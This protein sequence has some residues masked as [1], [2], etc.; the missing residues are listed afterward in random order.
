MK[1]RSCTDACKKPTASEESHCTVCHN[2]FYTVN[3]FD[4]HRKD[5]ETDE[6]EDIWCWV[7]EDC[8]LIFEKGMWAFPEEHEKRRIIENR[9]EAARAARGK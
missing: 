9:L 1:T 5:Y 7:P 2:N 3:A 4:E 6:S 8:G